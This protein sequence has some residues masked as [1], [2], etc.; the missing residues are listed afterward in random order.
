MIESNRHR[1]FQF[2][3]AWYGLPVD[4]D[5]LRDLVKLLEETQADLV[6]T[7]S[8]RYVQVTGWQAIDIQRIKW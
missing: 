2:L 8:V 1:A 4:E 7:V 5:R 3:M 6:E